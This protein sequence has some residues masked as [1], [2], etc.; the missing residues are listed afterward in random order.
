[1]NSTMMKR[2]RTR[3]FAALALLAVVGLVFALAPAVA[4]PNVAHAQSATVLIK[5]TGQTVLASNAP[6]ELSSSLFTQGAQAFTTGADAAGTTLGSIGVRFHTIGDLTTAGDQLTVTL[7]EDSN[8]KPGSALCTLT[9]PGTFSASG[10]QTFDAPTTDPCPA[11]AASTTYHVVIMLA[12]ADEGLIK[13][14]T[15][16]EPGEDDGGTAGWSIAYSRSYFH[17]LVMWQSVAN[18]PLLIEVSGYA[19]EIE[20]V[21]GPILTA[22]SVTA[23][24][25]AQ[26]LDQTF[27]GTE[28]RYTVTVAST[29]TQVTVAGTAGGDG[30]VAYQD[31]DGTALTDADTTAD[32]QQVTL[33]TQ[34]GGTPINVV[35]SYTESG[36]TTTQTY[37]LRVV[38][39]GTVATDRAALMAIYNN[40]G[41]ASW[42][43]NTNWGTNQALN[44]WSLVQ[45]VDSDGRVEQLWLGGVGTALCDGNNLVGTLPTALGT[46][47]KLEGL[48][49]CGDAG[50]TGTIPDLSNLT[51]LRSLVLQ[52]NGLTGQIPAWLGNLTNLDIQLSLW[53]N[54]FTGQIPSSLSNLN[55][56]RTVL[57]HDNQL[58]GPIPDLSGY[59]RL[60]YLYLYDNQLS[61]AIPD[62]SNS[63]ATL[64]QLLLHDNQ[65]SG[66]IPDL[67]NLTSLERLYLYDNQ[68]SGTI[69]DLSSL[70]SLERLY[71]YENQLTGTIPAW[72]DD[73]T[74][75]EYLLLNNN[76]LTG[77]IPDLSSLDSLVQLSLYDNDLTGSIPSMSSLP[78]LLY[79][80]LYDNELT[81]TIPALNTSLQHLGLS[82]NQLSG[83]ISAALSIPS[84]LVFV[85]LAGNAFS[86]CVPTRWRS[87][88]SRP[89][90]E[91][92]PAHDFIAVDKNTDG[93]TADD[94]DTPGLGLPF[95]LLSALTFS[96]V[97]L[98]PA[99]AGGT[100]AYTA[101]VAHNVTSTT[102]T[103]TKDLS[104][105]STIISVPVSIEKGSSTYEIGDDVPLDVGDNAIIVSATS[106]EGT[107]TLTYTV[108][109]TREPNAEPT[110][111]DGMTATRTLPENS[112]AGV[113]V[114]GGAVAATDSDS[115]DTLT[116]SLTGTDMVSFE[117]DS[118]G[119]I[120]TKTGVTHAFDFEDASNNSYSVTV[121]VRDS[122]DSDGNADMVTDDTITVT[123]N[124]TDVNDAP[125]FT[126]PPDTADFA[127][128]GTG[129]A[130]DFDA[131][132]QDASN[133]LQF[134]V[135]TGGDGG[136]FTINASTGALTFRNPPNFEMPTDVGDTAGNNTYVV[137]VKVEDNTSPRLNDTHT[138]TVTVT[139]VNEAPVITSPP[140]TRSVAENTTAVHMFAASDV[141]ASTTLMWSVETADDGDKFDINATT[142]ALSFKNA[143][144]F[145]TPTD[146]GMNNTYA[147]TVKVQDNGI[148]VE[149]DTHTV[150]VTVTNVNESPVITT[151]LMFYTDFDVEEN[152]ATSAVIKTYEAVDV[153]V[154]TTLTWS[155]EGNDAPDFTI[156]STINGI[157]NLH[158]RNAPN[159]E[160]PV[161]ADT[162]NDYDIR[163]K[164]KDNGIP[165]NRGSSNQL[166][167]TVSVEVTVLDLNE[168][169]EIF[170][171]PAP[172]FAEIEYDATSPDLTIETYTYTDEDRNPADTITWGIRSSFADAAH[173]NIGSSSGVLSFSIR[174]DFENAVD[175]GSNNTYE[176]VVEADDGQGESNS[177]GTFAVI[178]TV[179]N[180]D[181][182]PEIT[183][184]DA[185]HT[186]PSFMEI[187]YDDATAV[188]LTIADYDGDDEEEQ[189]ITWSRTGTDAGNFTIDSS[190]GVLSF[191]QRPNFEMPADA[192]TNNVYNVTVR[193]RDTA[194]PAN[195][196]ELEVV[197]TVTDVNERPDIDENFNAPQTYMEIEYD[198][199]GT[200]PDVHTFTATD[201]D[202]G[203]TIG[204]ALA[205]TDTDAAYLE[206]DATTGVL[207]FT[208]DSG[209]GHGPLPNFE[210]PRDDNADGSNTY[211]ITVR[212]TDDD[213]SNQKFTD[214]AVVITVTDV[215]EQPEFTGTPETA[216]TLD[217]HDANDNYVVMD[218]ADYVAY[219]E[220]G[221][222]TW[223]LTGTDR[224]DFAISADG[225]V[226]FVKT[227]NYEAPEDSGGNNVYEF[228]VVATD[229]QSGSS[230]RNVSIAVTVTVGDVEEAGT[231]T[232]D[233]LSPAAGETVTFRLTDPDGSI[234]TTNMTWVIQSLA[235]GGSWARVSG[236]L[237]PASTTFP[238]TVDEDVTGKAIR[239]MVTYT[240]RRGSG[241]TA[242]SQQTAQVTADP[243]VNA[244][245]RFR[246]D[247]D[248]SVEEGPAGGAVG[249]PT[250]A[251][252]RDND[253]LTY[254][255]QSG[256]DAAYFE[257]DPSTGQVSLAQA[258]DFETT[259]GPLF[260]YLTLHDGKGVD[261]N[262]VEVADSSIDTT[263]SATISV[264][265][266]EE[267]GVVTL[268][269]DEPETG[270]PLTA[271]LE[272]GDGGV[273]GEV[274]QWA[275]SE[276]GRTGW[277]NI[278]G[279]TSSSYTPTVADEDFFL[280]ATVTYTDRRGA[281][282]SA[283]AV[284]DDPVPSA[285]RRPR[286]PSTETGERTVPEDS[287]A[288][289]IIG[290]PV[291]ADD[292]ENDGLTYTLSGTDAGAF[293]I[294]ATTGQ[295]RV[296]DDLDFEMKASYS[297]TVEVHDGRD[298]MGSASTAVDDTQAVTITVENVEEPG[299]ITLTTDT[300]TI[301]ARAEVTAA[302]EDDDGVTGSVTWQW[303]RSPDGRTDWVNIAGATSAAYTPTLEEDRGNYIRATASYDDGHGPNK[304][305]E[306]VSAR[307]GDPPPV[308]SAPVF[309]STEDGQREVAENSPT[310]ATIGAPVAATDLNAGDSAVNDPLAYA[311][312]GTD[313]A[314]FTIDSGTGQLRV[315]QGVTLDY[316]GK[317]T[318]RVTVEVTD[319][320]DQN[321]DED[322]AAIDAR[323]SVTITVTD[324]NEA[325][326]VTGDDAPS[327]QE[328]S[329]AAIATYTAADPERD[330]LT[331]TV[332]NETEFWISQRGQ[333]YFRTP[334]SFE[335]RTS[336]TVTVTA[337]D[338]DANTALSGSLSVTVAVTDAEE[339]GV[340][341]IEPP[342]GWKDTPFRAEL[343]DGDDRIT[344]EMWQWERSPN[345]RSGWTAISGAISDSYLATT[346][347]VGQYLRVTVTYEDNRGSNKEASAA[348]T[349]R[350]E[351]STDR[352]VSN[353]APTFADTS[354]STTRTAHEGTAARTV[355]EGTAAGRNV[356]SPF[357]A[358]DP[359]HGDVLTYSLS[360]ADADDFDI[361]PATGQ[362]LTKAVLDSTVKDTYEVAVEV[363][364]G[365]DSAY[366][367]SATVDATI[368]LTI[369]VTEVAQRSSGGGGGGGGGG[370]FGPA[371]TAP[372]FVDGFRTERP[373]AV[374]ARPG[375]A[376]GD[377]V[378]ATHPN[379]DDVT[380]SLS[381]ANA[382]LFTVDAETGQIRL[383]KGATLEVGQTYTVNLTATDSTGTGAIIIVVIAVA[384]GVGDPY[385][386]NRNG[387]IEKDEVLRAIADYFA[388]RIEKDAVL[389]LVARYFSG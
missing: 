125:T 89:D 229:V 66:T 140:A 156:V 62:L 371:P 134:S 162:M 81:G 268:S 47:N 246:G 130:V 153:D 299:T 333:L 115:G 351:D 301:Q 114:V 259:P 303:A 73:L 172:S 383:G 181:E 191:A 311:L 388:G 169:P 240:D 52:D 228:N 36:T 158:F 216:I 279:A 91:G 32:G 343:T 63:A 137:T 285:N 342:R 120:K 374:T 23:G 386:A 278:S 223:S 106:S 318:Y 173:F 320:T 34:G 270:T 177:V 317:R 40:T 382:N 225:V 185:S 1:M 370:G 138:V 68:F 236:V 239:A 55:R 372:K 192:G 8:G 261:A 290:A 146:V 123:I 21:T 186:A 350:I 25:T 132:D 334:P 360:G 297:V 136:K 99:F 325:P 276:N 387:T 149:S 43:L 4:S 84:S 321:G 287:R 337:T 219:D 19:A 82:N 348:L 9:D 151:T 2:T 336:Y 20:E 12:T 22:L 376:V 75:L 277:T 284:T 128:N 113:N 167:D 78:S 61:G 358:S 203:D 375:D 253:A 226:T 147:V 312:S 166:D 255:I 327:F 260:F 93:D 157:A 306:K 193:A 57:L 389:E 28:Y 98:D 126:S 127:E 322:M 187:E 79:L 206:I 94:G 54:G 319:G 44:T 7:N 112:G 180:V 27:S 101:S 100:A 283:E 48:Y 249:A 200:R 59:T 332:S 323:R 272:D 295:I 302:L 231:L 274:W 339:E 159:F 316:E 212:A 271:T 6:L 324:V 88:L 144:D 245:P 208:Q 362:V 174:P 280:R 384:E 178:V 80:Y 163:V 183:T 248:W 119:Q 160:M 154:S 266:V 184:T 214:Y 365:F 175:M 242:L 133:T 254:G 141:D 117:I 243:I 170:G 258:L 241:K 111:D 110:F 207:T 24:G 56:L 329:S 357:R 17:P 124:L 305:A 179:T 18:R 14:T 64:E 199:T 69:P 211:T 222:V 252:D 378:S 269:T 194:S 150:T 238:W 35:V 330:T 361:N 215:N 121:N 131:S 335:A 142:G 196:R 85:R 70:T 257:I 171:D 369:T 349:G 53:G 298:G 338:D 148:P 237:T 161:D 50:V 201:Y 29:V 308:N 354:L 3:R 251:T 83:E 135:E 315:A 292:P 198:F 95:C 109:V 165:G 273:T 143:P 286:F 355:R 379:D 344:N 49:V 51:N 218:Q 247:S 377:P 197:V 189:T 188:L 76:E 224:R 256:G 264:V 145:E 107:P 367:P 96:G 381:G 296:Q 352:P 213:A 309:P 15:T 313:A 16:S 152:T 262:N 244:P 58:T 235:T 42:T 230:R 347:D 275:R 30:T 310:N 41:G 304:T 326:V 205:G 202:D 129:T 341:T 176:I 71:L 105:V 356:G 108:T 340:V 190:T 331:W 294:V 39:D 345:G 232:A 289:A 300:G 45:K 90:I 26:T 210:Y 363:H 373:L 209:F 118:N 31:A 87:V 364:D 67:S 353:S 282:K 38:R 77:T 92:L 263:R 46:L 155:L 233:N 366:N 182:T 368:T 122:K 359:D 37:A 195:T 267:D 164:V 10:V 234:D 328:D 314:S 307:V 168:A 104:Y 72:L 227:P 33:P 265:D 116:Y 288:G 103:A 220:E 281:G 86:G 293:T 65:L 291:A 97:D 11:F 74:S 60:Q 217:E 102:V 250:F 204:W 385:D 221:G 380:Y 5:N 139:D 13:L 346:N